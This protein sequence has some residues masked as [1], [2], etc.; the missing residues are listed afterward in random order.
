MK[1]VYD[2]INETKDTEKVYTI[3]GE[4]GTVHSVWPSKK[5]AEEHIKKLNKEIGSDWFSV[6]EDDIDEV[7]QS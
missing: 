4:D 3:T 2:I 5:D 1:T 6:K 7:I